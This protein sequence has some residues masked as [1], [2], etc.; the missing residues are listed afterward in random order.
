MVADVNGDDFASAVM[1]RLIALG[2][3]K[4]GLS[5]AAAGARGAH[6]ARSAKS[7][8]LNDLA[9]Q[10]GPLTILR[11]ADAVHDLP[12]E[13]VA[14][15]LKKAV[16]LE[17]FLQRWHRVETF[18][19]S[20][21]RVLVEPLDPIGYSLHH[22]S[23]TRSSTPT[24]AESLL[25]IAVVT[26]LAEIA[27]D[28]GLVLETDRGQLLRENASWRGLE[29]LDWSEKFYLIQT[30][31]QMREQ[32]VLEVTDSDLV[33]RTKGIVAQDLARRW[34]VQILSEMLAISKRT[35][36]RRLAEKGVSVS[37]LIMDARL[38][39]AAALLCE[40]DGPG[41]GA[42]GFL[43][44]FADQAHFSRSFAEHVGIPPQDYRK[45]FGH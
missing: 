37:Q 10:H 16:G 42:I 31:Q 1:M 34:S 14:V 23:K 2:M 7:A 44:G 5:P 33:E 15:A 18:S 21:N 20:S 6:V 17:D 38:E 41:L 8:A 22:V 9:A 25:V 30:S 11:L 3:E 43:T 26:V 29:T 24:L 28:H 40:S 4:Q 12:P 35:L 32:P 39:A 27:S 45:R 13:P 19:H 36:Q